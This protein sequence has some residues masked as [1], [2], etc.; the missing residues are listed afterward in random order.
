MGI[1]GAL[2]FWAGTLY[3]SQER[4]AE[5]TSLAEII[6]KGGTGLPLIGGPFE[7][8]DHQGFRRTDADFKGAYTMVYFGYSFCPDICP[9]AL[10][11]ITQALNQLG[12]KAPRIQPLFITLDSERDTVEHLSRYISLFHPRFMALT[13]T[14]AQI[15]AVK[16]AYRVYSAKVNSEE[17]RSEYVMD[18]SSLIYVMDPQGRFVAHFNHGTSPKEMA[19]VLNGLLK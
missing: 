15:E 8:V 9:E 10:Y 4:T 7:L 12:K 13:G 5:D 1:T 14:P 18:H 6:P 16:K 3:F 2:S 17:S 11:N 19:R